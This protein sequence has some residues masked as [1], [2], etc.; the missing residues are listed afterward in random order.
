MTAHNVKTDAVVPLLQASERIGVKHTK[1]YELIR[2][3]KLDARKQGSRTVI[4]LESI[5]QHIAS[6]P[7]LQTGA[8]MRKCQPAK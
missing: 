4:T 6:L 3:G 1:M 2:D 7:R 8:A 5:R